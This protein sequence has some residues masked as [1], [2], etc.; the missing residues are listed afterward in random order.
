MKLNLH[1]SIMELYA[2]LLVR[3]REIERREADG[4]AE[5]VWCQKLKRSHVPDMRCSTYATSQF[6]TNV[7]DQERK[8]CE[9]ALQL[10]EELQEIG[11]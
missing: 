11:K 6:F 7:R 9:R 8:Q 3:R 5:C 2:E 10:I 4:T 1:Q